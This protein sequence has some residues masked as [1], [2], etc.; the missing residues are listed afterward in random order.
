[1]SPAAAAAV[2]TAS[3]VK[4]AYSSASS[5]STT[6]P[7]EAIHEPAGQTLL[8]ILERYRLAR[9]FGKGNEKKAPVAVARTLLCI[10]WT[11]MARGAAYAEQGEDSCERGQDRNREHVAA[12]H[13][14]ALL[15]LAT[16]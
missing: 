11:V 7:R 3:L 8:R 1:M 14:Q 10:A 13:Q 16:R 6:G 4:R 15:R 5:A 9:R 12:R 2:P